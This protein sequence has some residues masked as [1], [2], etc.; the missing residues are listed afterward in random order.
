MRYPDTYVSP[1]VIRN[2]IKAI[3][4]PAVTY[5]LAIWSYDH[6]F[7]VKFDQFLSS[8]LRATIH[9]PS[10]MSH[11][12]LYLEFRILPLYWLKQ[13]YLALFI[14]Y[15]DKLKKQ[16]P[17]S[18]IEMTRENMIM[19]TE[20]IQNIRLVG[21]ERSKSMPSKKSIYKIMQRQ[22]Q[23]LLYP[24]SLESQVEVK[25]PPDIDNKSFDRKDYIN[26]LFGKYI[27]QLNGTQS[28][29]MFME[30]SHLNAKFNETK[31]F[32]YYS[33]NK[34]W[35]FRF[36]RFRLDIAEI[37][38]SVIGRHSNT[39]SANHDQ[40]L[41]CACDS[42]SI[43]LETRSHVDCPL[44]SAERKELMVKLNQNGVNTNSFTLK[45]L[46]DFQFSAKTSS[47]KKNSICMAISQF[48]T[49]VCE[50]RGLK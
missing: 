48:V 32:Y 38:G 33:S 45:D 4:L 17:V 31:P 20:V 35:I 6:L 29:K 36:I 21:K 25:L 26:S 42:K 1:F 46:L 40:E 10:E 43:H 12:A 9:G 8:V 15:L 39:H 50:K 24:D 22:E 23:K 30:A 37:K 7:A 44:Y 34:H 47:M 3:I 19:Q 41:K 28:A 13:Y 14:A 11:E 5:G 2:L 49:R 16:Y 27:D 18:I